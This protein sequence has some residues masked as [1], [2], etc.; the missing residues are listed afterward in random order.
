MTTF[1][2]LRQL[3]L[4][5]AVPLVVIL[6]LNDIGHP[7]AA[8]ARYLA[9]WC[10]LV[11][12]PGTLL[13]RTLAGGRSW[14][15]DLGFGSVLGLAW[16]LG[17]WAVFTGVGYPRQQ[18][19]AT[20]GL[21]IALLPLLRRR[22]P[23]RITWLPVMVLGLVLA[24]VRVFVELLRLTPLPPAQFGRHQDVWFQL[25]LVQA[26]E[27]YVV[28]PDLSAAGE[29]LIYHWFTNALMAA[30]GQ[31]SGVGAPEVLLHQW[32]MTMALTFVLAGWAAG[33][34]LSGM[35]WAGPVAGLVSLPEGCG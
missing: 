9:T 4:W 8:T 13:W 23:E 6:L 7:A 3:V 1:R 17:V 35:R 18:W 20:V 26:L 30:H 15:Q 14:A 24:A 5:A 27:K 12:L 22:S 10:V 21:V 19:M 28:P 2:V 34:L 31:V 33:E 32:P 11:L 29:P 25:G 16:A